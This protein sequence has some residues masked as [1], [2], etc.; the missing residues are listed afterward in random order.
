MGSVERGYH[1]RTTALV[2]R[3]LAKVRLRSS[4]HHRPL[5]ILHGRDRI[6]LTELGFRPLRVPETAPMRRQSP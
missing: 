2:T 4:Q 3:I 6:D 1:D 5:R